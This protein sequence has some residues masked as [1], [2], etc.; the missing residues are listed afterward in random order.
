M[1]M[2]MTTIE[3]SWKWKTAT[4]S[5]TTTQKPT[6]TTS[7][8]PTCQ[9]NIRPKIMAQQ[10]WTSM[11]NDGCSLRASLQSLG[12]GKGASKI[13][14]KMKYWQLARIYH[15]DKNNP[16]SQ[17]SQQRKHPNSLNYSTMQTNTSKKDFN[18]KWNWKLE[19]KME[20]EID[21]LFALLF[22]LLYISTPSWSTHAS[23]A[24]ARTSLH[25]FIMTS[26][27]RSFEL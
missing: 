15:P 19:L 23:P 4:T 27:L 12:L 1:K 5:T 6:T 10:S 18:F 24:S 3:T 8:L 26:W 17:D 21:Q 25:G 16:L 20:F 9:T 2:S 14:A 7:S 22:I 11:W 13:E